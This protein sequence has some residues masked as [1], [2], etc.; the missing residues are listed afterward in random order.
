MRVNGTVFQPKSVLRV[1]YRIV[2]SEAPFAL[3]V[4]QQTLIRA[5]IQVCNVKALL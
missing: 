3:C 2:A 1:L 4:T 5:L